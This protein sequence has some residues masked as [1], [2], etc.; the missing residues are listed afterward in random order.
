MVCDDRSALSAKFSA[1]SALKSV[2]PSHARGNPDGKNPPPRARVIGFGLLDARHELFEIGDQAGGPVGLPAEGASFVC[3]LGGP[4]RSRLMNIAS[5]PKCSGA[6]SS[7]IETT[8]SFRAPADRL[9]DRVRAR[10]AL[11]SHGMI[12]RAAL[13]LSPAAR[14]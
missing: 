12:D 8:G 14:R 7:V 6:C 11:F 3:A 1:V 13:P 5:H 4:G 10:H 2:H 9:A